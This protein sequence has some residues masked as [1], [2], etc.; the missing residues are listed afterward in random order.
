MYVNYCHYGPIHFKTL[1]FNNWF[2]FLSILNSSNISDEKNKVQQHLLAL[3][4]IICHI[5]VIF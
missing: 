3:S 2:R 5:F 4:L 1:T